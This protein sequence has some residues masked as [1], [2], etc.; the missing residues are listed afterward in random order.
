MTNPVTH[1]TAGSGPHQLML[2][3]VTV[4]RLLGTA[5]TGGQF[6][7]VQLTGLPGSGPGPHIDAWRETFYVLEGE[8]TFRYEQDA[9]VH[10]TVAGPGDAVTIP[11]GAGHAFNVTSAEPARYLI[12]SSPA[13]I[14]A[15]FADAGEPLDRPFLPSEPPAFDRDKLLAAF[16]KYGATRYEFPPERPDIAP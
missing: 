16:A 15:F 3:T 6:S 14:D 8:L 10:S 2:G 9:R 1:T 7:L 13:G 4:S 11:T 5:E 12:L